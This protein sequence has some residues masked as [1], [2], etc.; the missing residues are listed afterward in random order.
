MEFKKAIIV[1]TPEGDKYFN[2]VA[3]AKEFMRAPKIKEALM[4]L[5]E[6]NTELSDWLLEN[7]EVV[8]RAFE[9]GTIRRVTKK[10]KGLLSDGTDALPLLVDAAKSVLTGD[11]AKLLKGFMFLVENRETSRD[12][13]RYPTVQR[14]S[15]EEKTFAARNTILAEDENNEELADW[16]LAN[17]DGILTAYE[18]GVEKRPVNQ[19]ATD[20]LAAYHA[21]RAADKAAAEA[22]KTAG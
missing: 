5:T 4:E 21:K 14:M 2:T 20:A 12:S 9:T 19:K 17:R 3:E 11:N 1:E 10:E 8:E 13:F 15:E 16:V 6:S 7:R 18:A 22:A